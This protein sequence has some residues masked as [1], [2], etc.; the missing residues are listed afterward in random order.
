MWLPICNNKRKIAKDM[1]TSNFFY[2]NRCVAI[3]DADFEDGNLPECESDYFGRDK[4]LLQ[5]VLMYNITINVGY[6]TGG[7]I[8]Y[9]IND[10]CDNIINDIYGY[11]YTPSTKKELIN[12][13]AYYC[14]DYIKVSKRELTK[15]LRGLRI[16]KDYEQISDTLDNF[17]LPKIEDKVNDIIDN[18]K[19]EYGYIELTR[20][21]TMSNGEAIYKKIG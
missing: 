21:A 15:V 9:E 11:Y 6:Y 10:N 19:R 17:I 18:I 5:K 2:N 14:S 7:C 20:I 8:D 12:D 13:I 4:M 3:S 1:A 16:N